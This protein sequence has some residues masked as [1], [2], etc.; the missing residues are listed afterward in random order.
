MADQ[1]PFIYDYKQHKNYV[2][3]VAQLDRIANIITSTGGG[4]ANN[5]IAAIKLV[6]IV[7]WIF[8]RKI[9]IDHEM[10]IAKQVYEQERI[11]N[12]QGQVDEDL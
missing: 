12:N 3:S 6:L 4:Y 11:N 7:A 10:L 5:I 8:A 9:L 2:L 1:K